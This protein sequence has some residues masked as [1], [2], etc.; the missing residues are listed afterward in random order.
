METLRNIASQ[1]QQLMQQVNQ[2]GAQNQQL[3]AA[4]AQLQGI[5]G[6][7]Q[8]LPGPSGPPA[9]VQGSMPMGGY[10]W[11]RAGTGQ[12]TASCPA[13]VMKGRSL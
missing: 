11:R 10:G 4:N 13:T 3:Q 9:G 1:M 7:G 5:V 8:G 2:L 6:Q 12:W